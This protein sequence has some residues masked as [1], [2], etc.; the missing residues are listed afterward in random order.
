MNSSKFIKETLISFFEP[1]KIEVW[2]DPYNSI[3]LKLLT[4]II[5]VIEIWAS[6]VM[7]IFVSYET[8]GLFGHYR[9]VINQLLSFGY[10]AVS[11]CVLFIKR[12]GSLN[13]FEVLPHPDLIFHVMKIFFDPPCTPHGI[14]EINLPTLFAYYLLFALY[15]LQSIE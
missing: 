13:Y 14:N 4:I 8:K 5:Y 10:G 15:I 6:I 2:N 11:Y 9:T 12:T 7:L 1:D 3:P